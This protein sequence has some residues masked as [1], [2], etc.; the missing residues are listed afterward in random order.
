MLSFKSQNFSTI[1]RNKQALDFDCLGA[2]FID[3]E[4]GKLPCG[5]LCKLAYFGRIIE[6]KRLILM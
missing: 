4:G 1:S 2:F 6:I 3:F 5:L